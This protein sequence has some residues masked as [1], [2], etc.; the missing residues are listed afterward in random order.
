MRVDLGASP[1][2]RSETNLDMNVDESGPVRAGE[3]GLE[4]VDEFGRTGADEK[5]VQEAEAIP[6]LVLCVCPWPRT[7]TWAS[8]S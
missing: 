7:L 4:R 1:S 5:V 6:K 3:F 2:G 8:Q